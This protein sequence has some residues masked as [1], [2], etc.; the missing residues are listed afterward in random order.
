M[1]TIYAKHEPYDTGHLA[2][3]LDEMRLTGSP[4]IHCVK[5]DGMI[6]ALDGSHRLAAAHILGLPVK[7]VLFDPDI[8]DDA[9]TSFWQRVA[10]DRP[11]YELAAVHLHFDAYVFEGV[12]N[13]D[14]HLQ[15]V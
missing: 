15:H 4:T 14:R 3:V 8:P 12:P 6:F 5:Y 10:S 2:I 11:I 9:L 1:A 13:D 7:V